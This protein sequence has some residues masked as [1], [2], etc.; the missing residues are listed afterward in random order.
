MIE[1]TEALKES[2]D[3]ELYQIT[4][5][6]PEVFERVIEQQ[7]AGIEVELAELKTEAARLERE[8]E[9][10]TGEDAPVFG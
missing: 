10:L 4:E 8:I 1:A 7:I 3:Y 9:E 6:E 2:P 5:R